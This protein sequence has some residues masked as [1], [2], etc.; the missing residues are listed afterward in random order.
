MITELEHKPL[1]TYND[2][3]GDVSVIQQVLAEVYVMSLA[4]YFI[5]SHDSGIGKLAFWI[6]NN[7]RDDNAF[8]E[9]RRDVI[10]KDEPICKP[11][12]HEQMSITNSGI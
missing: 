12:N 1:H 8:I 6:S 11:Y 9:H 2:G 3:A 7:R 4:N 5:F 10:S